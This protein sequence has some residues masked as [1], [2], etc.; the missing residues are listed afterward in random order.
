MGSQP[1]CIEGLRRLL[2]IPFVPREHDAVHRQA[3]LA[4]LTWK[5]TGSSA[6]TGLD[7]LD[8]SIDYQGHCRWRRHRIGGCL[9]LG[10]SAAVPV[11]HRPVRLYRRVAAV[12]RLSGG[13]AVLL[14]GG[15]FLLLL[16]L[17]GDWTRRD[18]GGALSEQRGARHLCLH[19]FLLLLS[20][21]GLSLL[22]LR[23]QASAPGLG[24]ARH[25]RGGL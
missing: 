17:C 14:Q 1:R 24:C 18:A 6:R 10:R 19:L 2:Y 8:G 21:L 22:L 3:W 20:G 16:H 25:S 13:P 11:P 15:V 5:R 23:P 12:A 9:F 7:P 4:L